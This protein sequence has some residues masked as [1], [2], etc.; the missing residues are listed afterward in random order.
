MPASSRKSSIGSRRPPTKYV[1]YRGD[2]LQHGKKTGM[3]VAYVDHKSDE[4]EPFDKVISQADQ[5]TPPRVHNARKRRTPKP[6]TPIVEEEDDENGE[7]SMDLEDSTA[8]SPSAYFANA[9]VRTL[10]SSVQRVGSSLRPVAHGADV[11]FD[12]VPSPRGSPAVNGRKSLGRGRSSISGPSHLSQSTVAQDFEDIHVDN[13]GPS[14]DKG[15]GFGGFD[16]DDSDNEPAISPPPPQSHPKVN[17]HVSRRT[18]FAQIDQEDEDEDQ[19]PGVYDSPSARARGK[20]RASVNPP[21]QDED[22]EMEDEIAQGFAEI[23]QEPMDE[24][25]QEVEEERPRKRGVQDKDDSLQKEQ[26]AS[27]KKRT[28]NEGAKK[29]R[30]RPRKENVLREVIPDDNNADGLRRGTRTRYKPLDWWRCE[31]VVYGRRESGISLVPTIKEILRIPKEEPEPLGAKYRRRKKL[32]S[33]SKSQPVEEIDPASLVYNPEEGWDTATNPS[34]MVEDYETKTEITRR[35]A[36][37][38]KML[39]PKPAANND[40]FFQK[41]FGDGDFI[42]AGQLIIPPNKQKP[43]KSTRDN[44]FVFYVIEGAVNFKVHH[45]SYILTTGGVFLVPRGNMYY[46]ENVAER[47]AKLFFAQARKV[48]KDEDEDDNSSSRAR[49]LSQK[50]LL[51]SHRHSGGG[52]GSPVA[53]RSSSARGSSETLQAQPAHAAGAAALRRAA[54]TK[55]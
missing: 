40:F 15:G 22:P 39:T 48:S 30:G 25:V 10:T 44:T 7:M 41:I 29:P 42:A 55:T 46:I 32:R 34:G 9:R 47:D 21:R 23:E 54:S 3:A 38:A 33:K 1:P 5:R 27:K 53:H 49:S 37:T 4:F 24:D 43:T 52:S 19:E 26:P 35:V 12:K 20:Q 36:F 18:S 50:L 45:T 51:R 2:D 17:G 13:D 16:D 31:K 28:E 6:K 8:K 14:M 11:D